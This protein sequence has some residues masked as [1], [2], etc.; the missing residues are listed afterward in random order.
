[1]SASLPVVFVSGLSSLFAGYTWD[2]WLRS[3]PLRKQPTKTGVIQV[4]TQSPD[5]CSIIL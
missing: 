3:Y 1:M 2:M 5:V 4:Q